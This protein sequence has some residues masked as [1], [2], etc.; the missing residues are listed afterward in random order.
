MSRKLFIILAFLLA[1]QFAQ[2]QDEQNDNFGDPI[3][4]G[5][6]FGMNFGYYIPSA[7]QAKFYDGSPENINNINYVFKNKFYRD[8]I[9]NSLNASDTFLISA[10]PQNM[11]YTGAFSIGLYF[12]RTFDKYFGFSVQFDYSKLHANDF[13]QLEVDP[14]IILTEPDLRLFPIWGIEER[15]NIDLNFSKYFHAHNEIMVPFLEAGININSTRVK[16]NM[17]QINDLKYSLVDVYLNGTYVPG[18]QQTQYNIQQGG[19]GWGVSAGGGLRLIFSEAVSID[20]GF[21]VYYQ[22]IN[23]ENYDQFR[24]GFLFYVR[25]SL[26]G[27]FAANE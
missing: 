20:P 5:W 13:F 23:L 6:D 9:R 12:R 19:I 26:T 4:T 16:E 15:V 14:N 24:P 11:R 18:V 17:I 7:F 27:F 21:S 22:K 8:Q 1:V 3:L 10:M 2:A 25:L